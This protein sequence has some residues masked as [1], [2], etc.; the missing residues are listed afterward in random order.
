M[1]RMILVGGRGFVGGHL[2][3]LARGRWD[4]VVFD[5]AP[6]E[7]P[8]PAGLP[9]SARRRAVDI[10]DREAVLAAIGQEAPHL[11]VNA[12]AVSNID[13]AERNMLAA[14]QVNVAGAGYLAEGCRRY[15][16]RFIHF[17]SD[18][19][20]AGTADSYG[21]EDAPEPVNYYGRTK[22]ESEALVLATCPDSVVIRLSL[23]LGYAVGGGGNSFYEPLEER[24]RRG[25]TVYVPAEEIRTPVAVQTLA[26]AVLELA[27][28]DY[29]GILHIGSTDS[30]SRYELARRVAAA[31]GFSPDLVQPKPAGGD[32]G[33][34]P[35][36]L[37]G[38]IRVDRAQAV[39]KR[40]KLAG[41]DT[42]IRRTIEER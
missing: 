29:R 18:A 8:S 12:A 26:E 2:V 41:V 16:A 27:E 1:K 30:V 6:A 31:M 11:V 37:R 22:A 14:H 10:T 24:L 3:R 15:E 19:V 42:Y 33:R 5:R 9:A 39:L 4:L 7:P 36:H 20:F 17:S 35:R 32:P 21:E 38:V 40:T 23:V 13:F 25:E 28:G 34:A